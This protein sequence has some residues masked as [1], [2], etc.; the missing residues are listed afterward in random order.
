M[1]NLL[2]FTQR[3]VVI[4]LRRRHISGAKQNDEIL[5]SV[6]QLSDLECKHKTRYLIQVCG[7]Q[8]VYTHLLPKS[9][10]IDNF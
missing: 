8:M 4:S 10:N 7:L 3:C 2:F 6:K 1:S 9:T 5:F